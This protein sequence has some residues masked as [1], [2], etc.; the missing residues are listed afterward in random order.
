VREK[1][2]VVGLMKTEWI[3]CDEWE[4]SSATVRR[5]FPAAAFRHVLL[6]QQ[7]RRDFTHL[8]QIG[9]REAPPVPCQACLATPDCD[10]ENTGFAVA[11]LSWGRFWNRRRIAESYG[12]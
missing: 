8:I 5:D 4:C 10:N 7:S 1:P 9:R 11:G 3:A 2:T 6:R 12:I